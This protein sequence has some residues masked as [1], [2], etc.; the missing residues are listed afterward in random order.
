KDR[1]RRYE[2]A[3]GL[4]MDVQRYL[5]N[6]PVVARPPTR[7]YRLQKLVRRNKVTF[8][9]G[10]IV[11]LALIGGLGFATFFWYQE[12]AERKRAVAAEHV[13]LAAEQQQAK[14][15]M[16]A[17]N[18]ERITQAA[19]LISQDKIEE[20]DE[21][22][23]K[24]SAAKPSLEAENVLRTLG[25]W[26][27]LNGHWTQAAA[28]FNLLLQVDQNDNSWA[29]TDDLLMAG[30][31][32]IE[33]GDMQGYEQFRRA[34]IARYVGITDPI[35]AER[36]LKIS[37]LLPADAQMMSSLQSFSDVSAV[38]LEGKT[39]PKDI[40]AAWR[41]ISLAIMAYRQG[42]AP[43]AK[44][45]CE[46]CLAYSGNNPPR[47][48]TAHIIQAMACHRLGETEQAISE[49]EEGRKPVEAE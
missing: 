6:E 14:L 3:N 5:N 27:A 11:A 32:L 23:E 31:I 37:L 48:A 24:V 39:N 34:A 4:A 2:T 33:R 40:M 49:L 12:R 43:T 38:S 1:K 44:A 41:C 46:K 47:I 9:A 26:H 20:A 8:I 45:W 10:A 29:I 28:R 18:R 7:F 30:P 22:A 21:L 35:F 16:E 19:F 15:R 36:T 25:K 42:Y 17:E 13:A